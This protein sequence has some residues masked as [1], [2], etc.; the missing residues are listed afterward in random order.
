MKVVA[1][2][3]QVPDPPAI[4][5][6]EQ[7]KSL[8]R[9]GVPLVLN[10]F[11]REA[12]AEA[13]AIRDAHGG[14]TVVMTMGPPQAEEALR[15]CLALGADRCIHLSDRLFAL[16]DTIGTSRTLALALG[17]EGADLVVCGRKTIDA[18]TWQVPPEVAAF[19]GWPHV[20][21]AI[22]V[23]QSGSALHVRR[24]TDVGEDVYEV[25]PPLVLSLARPRV[26]PVAPVEDAA[27]RITTWSARDLVPD[28][29]PK[30]KRFGQPGSP[31]RVLAVRD[32]TPERA[33]RRAATAA[34]LAAAVTDL[35]AARR[36]D[37]PTWDKPA[38]IADEPG[39]S[40]D[41][42]VAVELVDGRPTRLSLELVGQS[43]QLAGK[44]GGVNVTVCLGRDLDEAAR[45]LICH[46]AERV[47]LVDD[48]RLAGYEPEPSA[49]AL[50]QVV[51]QRRPHVV[52]FPASAWGRDLGPRLAGELA[53]GMT[54]DCVGVDIAKAGRLLQRKPA[55]GGNIVSV[56]MGS[57]SPQLAT[58]RAR[59]YEPLDAREG[60]GAE[61][62]RFGVDGLPEPRAR[63]VERRSDAGA[64]GHA[65]DA[66]DVV[67]CV[68]DELGAEVAAVEDA[69]GGH[70]AV[71]G[72]H[73]VC[74]DGRLPASR[75]IG[76]YGRPVAPRLLIALGVTGEFW[77]V[78]GWVM[79]DVVAA[80]NE[81]VTAMH[82]AAD[83]A[84]AGDW[85][86]A[87]PALLAAAA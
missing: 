14:E 73:E 43:R 21:G 37:P 60:A 79:A 1:L 25:E 16:A 54:G 46:G 52:L 68:G 10:P 56:I 12:V 18:E 71:G 32:A 8:R 63:L 65:L 13:V 51:E 38:H 83:V 7:T 5:F 27:R 33:G 30:D 26:E 85:R 74:A 41:S 59:M 40:Y 62:E 87:L 24:Q 15:E 23:R 36:R 77:H 72:T 81:G 2:V 66:A 35:L 19:L 67:V 44:L 50:R 49:A 28:A 22:G 86:E 61:V 76:L 69:V 20:T 4:E 82:P 57:T 48:E 31:T 42:W 6:D 80:V 29:D 3:K 78:T 58:V 11:D 64:D 70:A 75:E 47:V 84:L 34:D 9:E 53:L 45:E 55:Y 17:K 39:R